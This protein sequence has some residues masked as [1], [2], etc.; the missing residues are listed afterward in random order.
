MKNL[1]LFSTVFLLVVSCGGNHKPL[2]REVAPATGGSSIVTIDSIVAS[3]N[4][5][6][7]Y[8]MEF[9]GELI[10][11][12]STSSPVISSLGT[13]TQDTTLNYI[14]IQGIDF[15]VYGGDGVFATECEPDANYPEHASTN[16]KCEIAHAESFDKI[17]LCTSSASNVDLAIAQNW[18]G[19]QSAME[20][21]KLGMTC[22]INGVKMIS[23]KIFTY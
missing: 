5:P 15:L 1:I 10:A 18:P 21:E 22:W 17:I 16:P 8:Q 12:L 19:S 23:S 4:Y 9:K 14:T 2:E 7:V 11:D 6:Q 13:V 3:M 20:D